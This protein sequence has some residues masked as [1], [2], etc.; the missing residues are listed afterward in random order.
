M[1]GGDT[2]S[3]PVDRNDVGSLLS[4]YNKGYA[5]YDDMFKAEDAGL[6][7]V[8]HAVV[9]EGYVVVRR[10]DLAV[11]VRVWEENNWSHWPD[12][13]PLPND[14]C[15]EVDDVG[16]RLQELLEGVLAES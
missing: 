1:E 12:G 5:Q 9:P 6:L 3:E 8:A 11:M 16:S 2:M 15:R 4:V 10:D 13:R 7:A 14:Y